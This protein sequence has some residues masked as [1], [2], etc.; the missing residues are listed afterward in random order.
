MKILSIENTILSR[1]PICLS[2]ISGISAFYGIGASKIQ[3][4]S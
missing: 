1:L 4:I 3:A 2:G